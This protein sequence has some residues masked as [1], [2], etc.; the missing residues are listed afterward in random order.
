MVYSQIPWLEYI[1][2]IRALAE[3]V[4]YTKILAAGT[5]AYAIYKVVYALCLSPLRKVPGP[6]FARLT[7]MRSIIFSVTGYQAHKAIEEYEKYGDVYVYKPEAVSISNPE[8]LRLVLGS[9][10][11]TK[12]SLYDKLDL[13]GEIVTIAARDPQFAKIRRRQIGP[14]FSHSYLAKMEQNIL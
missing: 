11:F 2:Q 1:E 5:S 8:D 10:D 14:Y 6:L 13:L 4:G 9:H 12:T 3:R 7:D